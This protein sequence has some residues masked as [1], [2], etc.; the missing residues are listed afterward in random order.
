M[1]TDGITP[2]IGPLY[3]ALDT[4]NREL[5]GFIP[6]VSRNTVETR[7]K[8]GQEVRSPVVTS[9]KPRDTYEG[10]TS[11]DEGNGSAEEVVF[12]IEKSRYVP[13]KFSG[14]EDLGTTAS[15][16]YDSIVIGKI[17]SAYR[18][19]INEMEEY[20][21]AKAIAGGT[22]ATGT[23]GTTPFGTAGNLMDFANL[24][25][26]LDDNGA[27]RTDRNLV[28]NST[29]MANLRGLQT[30]LLKANEAGTTEF[31]RTGYL[32]SP[33]TGF[34]LFDSAGLVT[35]TAGTATGLLINKDPKIAAG[36]RVLDVDTGT[37][38]VLPG[39]IITINGDS[40]KYVVNVGGTD[41]TSLTIGNPGLLKDAANNAAVT[42]GSDYLP[43]V[44]FQKDAIVL[45][46]RLPSAPRDGDAAEGVEIITDPYTG[47]QFEARLY[48]QHR[49]NVLEIGIA[50][51]AVVAKP[52][53][54]ALLLG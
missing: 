38:T 36:T 48:K 33:L 53:N 35:H 16:T 12:T 27:P 37:G 11:A 4:F 42:V 30:I 3:A 14:E 22:R 23:A 7:V 5:T 47:I 17:Q 34:G 13:I 50:Y 52:D 2:F 18:Q 24:A 19:L 41:P 29:A 10:N 31:L 49:Q 21:A 8:I 54:V 45:G 32:T 40:N 46:T 1:A 15:G 6:S 25:K 39:D 9:D 51:G 43:S 28:V 20:L 26:I 44:A